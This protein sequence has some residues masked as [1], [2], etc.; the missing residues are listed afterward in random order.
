MPLE[1][2][3]IMIDG[4][5]FSPPSRRQTTRGMRASLRSSGEGS[6]DIT[7][8]LNGATGGYAL[9]TGS[10]VVMFLV[11]WIFLFSFN[12]EFIQHPRGSKNEHEPDTVKV[13]FWA[14]ILSVA[15]AVATAAWMTY[16]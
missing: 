10:F 2:D 3:N 6:W 12:F 11:F 14:L 13:F 15:V 8:F 4:D 9:M 16:M 1:F 7:R 5:N